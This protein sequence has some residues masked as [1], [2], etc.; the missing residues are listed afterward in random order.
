[1]SR[2]LWSLSL[3]LS[4]LFFR[5]ISSR[6]KFAILI[7]VSNSAPVGVGC[8]ETGGGGD[9][10]A[11]TMLLLLASLPKSLEIRQ[12]VASRLKYFLVGGRGAND[13]KQFPN[14][15]E[16]DLPILK[17]KH[18]N[19]R[20]KDPNAKDRF[21]VCGSGEI[22][23]VVGENIDLAVVPGCVVEDAVK[24]SASD[25]QFL[26]ASYDFGLDEKAILYY[27]GLSDILGLLRKNPLPHGVEGENSSQ[28][29]L[30]YH[31]GG[32]ATARDQVDGRLRSVS[33]FIVR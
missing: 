26:I 29:D 25:W 15:V 10:W 12:E 3:S 24:S 6:H 19:I 23:N 28:F 5:P 21:A 27:H 22:G 4:P 16:H 31:G 11:I 7:P 18:I 17:I 14:R 2:H 30:R 32:K 20:L 9:N 13:V 33:H 8:N 1:M